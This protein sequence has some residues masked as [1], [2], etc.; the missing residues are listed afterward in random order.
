[1][2]WDLTFIKDSVGEAYSKSGLSSYWGQEEHS[3]ID[4]I[5]AISESIDSKRFNPIKIIGVG[6]SGIVIST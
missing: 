2:T 6:G 1:M 5:S 3:V 4:A